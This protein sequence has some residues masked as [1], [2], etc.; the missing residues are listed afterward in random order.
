MILAMS[1]RTPTSPE[2]GISAV[3]DAR[4]AMLSVSIAF[5]L[6]LTLFVSGCAADPTPLLTREV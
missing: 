6:S 1:L 4:F 3:T 5:T 2:P